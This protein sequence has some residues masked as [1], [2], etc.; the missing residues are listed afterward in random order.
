MCVGGGCQPGNKRC[1]APTTP[2][3][4][5]AKHINLEISA[6]FPRIV[7]GGSP[8]KREGGGRGVVAASALP[9]SREM[10]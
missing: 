4:R 5:S 3:L 6:Q 9:Y 2:Y 8:V 7:F 1:A 10:A